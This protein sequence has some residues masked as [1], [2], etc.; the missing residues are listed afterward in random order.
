MAIIGAGPAGLAAA[1]VLRSFPVDYVVVD[2]GKPIDRRDR[3]C[4]SDVATGV[5]GA[6]LFSD[7]K[8][9]FFPAS[10]HL[11]RLND[12]EVLRDSYDWTKTVLETY[13]L[14][15]PPCPDLGGDGSDEEPKDTWFL[16]SYP[17]Y[18]IPLD[19]RLRMTRDLHTNAERPSSPS[20]SPLSS[21]ATDRG[22]DRG[23]FVLD[24]MVEGWRYDEEAKLFRF[25]LR[26]RPSSPDGG[27]AGERVVLT[28]RYAIF[29]GGRFFPMLM[30]KEDKCPMRFMRVEVGLRI[31]DASDNPFFTEIEGL[32]P[33]YKFVV[34]SDGAG[35]PRIEWRTFCCCRQGETV[36]TDSFGIATWSG[37][38][39]CPPT[40]LSNIGFN[41]RCLDPVGTQLLAT[42]SQGN[43]SSPLP[44]FT[45]S[46]R[47][48]LDAPPP[49]LAEQYG[50]E[51]AHYVRQ[52]LLLLC[53]Q[54]PSLAR[55]DTARLIG[56]TIEGVGHYP[57]TDGDLK[58]S[59][60][61]S[62]WVA[63]DA[64]GTF[65]GIVAAMVSGAYA[66]H[67]VRQEVAACDDP[68]VIAPA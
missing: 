12:R 54:F 53:E 11:W 16:K 60:G 23:D 42:L 47:S 25:D 9:S 3:D 46:L 24:C 35:R 38:A 48:L 51:L 32:D 17:S 15:C 22:G 37:R 45:S 21:P 34:D 61:W 63:G 30:A 8:Y 66:A 4:A 39:D 27:A 28:A 49:A 52:G 62:G 19:Q 58:L 64:Q 40:Q 68:E 56:P 57:H 1:N 36:Q 10:T 55:S 44:T 31:E 13:G 26:R 7:G 6:G 29:A 43:T 20:P 2:G 59:N 5:G 65:R 18:Y 67:K 41:T 33:K 14:D 50:A